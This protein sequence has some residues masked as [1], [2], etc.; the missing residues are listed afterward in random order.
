MMTP[1]RSSQVVLRDR[2]PAH[3]QRVAEIL[4]GL[5]EPQ[6]RIA[7]KYFYD[8]RGSR[9]FDAICELPEYYLT[10]T[11]TAILVAHAE[12]IAG[13]I[14]SDALLIEYGSGSSL[15][16]RLLLD[17]MPR[18]AAYVPVDISRSY[19]A[20]CA[21]SLANDYP[22]LRVLPVC[23]DFTR[24]FVLP[25]DVREQRRRVAFFPGSTLGNFAREDAVALLAQM[26]VTVGAHGGAVIGT[27]R[28]K[29]TDVI[30]AAYDDAQRVTAA[31][32]RNVLVRLNR[33]FDADFDVDAFAHEAPWVEAQQRIEMRLVSRERQ[34]VRV[35]GE[36]FE[37]AAGEYILTECCHK[38]TPQRIAALAAEAGWTIRRTWSDAAQLFD[39]HYLEP[40]S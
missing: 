36:R 22:H 40:R 16:T 26:R 2:T 23:A 14:G 9:L 32:N 8:E 27:D 29:P 20:A 10:R 3:D 6:K 31:F 28:V 5:G 25:A 39:V 7:P 33:E 19:L 17:R 38:F 12:E 4:E 15:K 37:F 30:E 13:A 1:P 11:E 34:S 24:P 35:A 21:Q 18:L